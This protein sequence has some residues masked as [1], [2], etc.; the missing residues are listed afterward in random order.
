MTQRHYG[1]VLTYIAPGCPF[2]A[3][4]NRLVITWTVSARRGF[5]RPRGKT[6]VRDGVSAFVT[7]FLRKCCRM[8]DKDLRAPAA[9]RVAKKQLLAVAT[10]LKR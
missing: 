10:R 3:F 8:S 7:V 4:G 9:F 5:L 2:T 6:I 1:H